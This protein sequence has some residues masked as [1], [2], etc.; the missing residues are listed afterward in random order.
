M[1]RR[2][3][4]LATPVSYTKTKYKNHATTVLG[5]PSPSWTDGN[6]TVDRLKTYLL[7]VSDT[8]GMANVQS[9]G[10]KWLSGTFLPLKTQYI[11]P[12]NTIH[13]LHL[14]DDM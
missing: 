13:L 7:E 6:K 11:H 2:I 9:I 1:V 10:Q 12:K 8:V 4:T 3:Q 14:V 5:W